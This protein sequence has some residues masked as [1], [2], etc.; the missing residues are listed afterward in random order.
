MNLL[1]GYPPNDPRERLNRASSSFATAGDRVSD[2][3]LKD[4]WLFPGLGNSP[5]EESR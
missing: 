1:E 3:Y 5:P 2:A 4:D